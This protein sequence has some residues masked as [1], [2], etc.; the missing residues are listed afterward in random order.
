MGWLNRGRVFV[1]MFFRIAHALIFFKGVDIMRSVE[2]SG[3][4]RRMRRQL[5]ISVTQRDVL[6]EHIDRAVPV[7]VHF[8][9]YRNRTIKVLIDCGALRYDRQ[10]FPR[11][12]SLTELGRDRLCKMLADYADTL[13]RVELRR[14]AKANAASNEPLTLPAYPPMKPRR[15]PCEPITTPCHA[16]AAP[17]EPLAPI[18]AGPT[19]P[20]IGPLP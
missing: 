5:S 9:P 17:M 12:T 2:N 20:Q 8:D 13:A 16:A 3:R 6:I 4:R 1:G 14:I 19:T 11:F 15:T 7:S 10:S 18:I